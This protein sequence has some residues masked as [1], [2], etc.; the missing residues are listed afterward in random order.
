MQPRRRSNLKR[1]TATITTAR[2]ITHLTIPVALRPHLIQPVDPQE[3]TL[4]RPAQIVP[5]KTVLFNLLILVKSPIQFEKKDI[6]FY[7]TG[8]SVNGT[9]SNKTS[10]INNNQGDSDSESSMS[11]FEDDDAPGM[12]L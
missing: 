11:E 10:K 7:K 12:E 5:S 4:P 6:L 1:T 9:P 8:K 2:Q 3:S